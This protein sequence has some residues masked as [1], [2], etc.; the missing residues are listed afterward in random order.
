MQV[1][2][3][4]D[5]TLLD[6]ALVM[7]DPAVE[8]L[9]T[10]VDGFSLL[11]HTDTETGMAVP[12]GEGLLDFVRALMGKPA[13]VGALRREYDDRAL[14]DEMLSSLLARGFAHL[15]SRH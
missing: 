1:S 13:C 6:D 15:M 3:T 4:A 8:I 11:C 2:V 9:D 14:I 10:E 5:Q 12:P 7:L